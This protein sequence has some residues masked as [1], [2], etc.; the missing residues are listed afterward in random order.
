MNCFKVENVNFTY[1]KF[2]KNKRNVLSNI[3]F[4]VDK[5]DFVAIV[6][7]TGSGKSTLVSLLNGLSKAD[8]GHI[9]FEDKDIYDKEYDLSKLRFRCGVVFQYPEYQLFSETVMEDI[10]FGALKKGLSIDAAKDKARHVMARLGIT[11]LDDNLPFTLSGGEKRK[12]AFAG[13]LVT[14]PDVLILDEPEAGLDTKSKK[15]LFEFLTF[16]NKEKHITILFITHDLDDA[17]EYANK[18][19]LINDGEIKAYGTPYEVFSNDELMRKCNLEA[20]YGVTIAKKLKEKIEIDTNRIKFDDIVS[21]MKK[22]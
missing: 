17:V 4:S 1:D 9:Y 13:V 21:Y 15:E 14:E 5:E 8:S 22:L 7:H 11:G 18:V 20:P 19:L 12:V 6:G 10:C 3:S 2:D 16:L